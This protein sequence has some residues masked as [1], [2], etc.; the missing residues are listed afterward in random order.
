MYLKKTSTNKVLLKFYPVTVTNSVS[1]KF[2]Y[3]V[4]QVLLR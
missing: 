1:V 3:I 2:F 4:L